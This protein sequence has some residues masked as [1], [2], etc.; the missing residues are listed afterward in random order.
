MTAAVTSQTTDA[1]TAAGQGSSHRTVL[2]LQRPGELS[3]VRVEHTE[4]G[5][6][7]R[8]SGRVDVHTVADVRTALREALDHGYGELVVDCAA[9]ELGDTTGLGALLGA[10]RRAIRGGRSLV[11]ANVPDALTRLLVATRLV[12]IFR[13]REELP[14]ATVATA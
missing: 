4:A 5:Q 6:R 9:V 13:T 11:L 12:R 3:A 14:A 2:A 8:L 1:V 7:L 10:H